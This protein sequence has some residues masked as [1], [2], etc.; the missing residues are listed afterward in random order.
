MCH[1]KAGVGSRLVGEDAF[2]TATEAGQLSLARGVTE[3]VVERASGVRYALN[4]NEGGLLD[5]PKSLS[6][7]SRSEEDWL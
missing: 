3:P 1:F 7:E 2:A 6:L 5:V 4:V